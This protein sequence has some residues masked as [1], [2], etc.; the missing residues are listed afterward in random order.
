M[1]IKHLQIVQGK[2]YINGWAGNTRSKKEVLDSLK[3]R[4]VFFFL[5]FRNEPV[6][7][8]RNKREKKVRKLIDHYD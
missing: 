8:K 7:Y 6:I 4:A 3:S 2:A 5:R 1:I